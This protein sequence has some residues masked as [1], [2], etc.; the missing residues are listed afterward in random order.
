MAARFSDERMILPKDSRTL[1]YVTYNYKI[2]LV[3]YIIIKL[4]NIIYDNTISYIIYIQYIYIHIYSNIYI[5]YLSDT[6]ISTIFTYYI[7][8]SSIYN[9]HTSIHIS[10]YLVDMLIHPQLGWRQVR[11]RVPWRPCATVCTKSRQR[12]RCAN[13]EKYGGFHGKLMDF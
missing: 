9:I 12:E 5:I 6:W 4:Y 11:F 1:Y 8:Y 7:Y 13:D 10:S 2:I 3:I